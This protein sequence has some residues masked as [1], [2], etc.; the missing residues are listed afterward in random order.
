MPGPNYGHSLKEAMGEVQKCMCILKNET[1]PF[2]T[3]SLRLRP[4]LASYDPA[5]LHALS[6]LNAVLLIF[7]PTV[8][9]SHQSRTIHNDYCFI[10]ILSD[11]NI[12]FDSQRV[13][14]FT[15]CEPS[16]I[17]LRKQLACFDLYNIGKSSQNIR[18]NYRL[19][20]DR[21]MKILGIQ[22]I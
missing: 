13:N 9:P 5:L 15:F 12:F 3:G 2:S 18:T 19:S 17:V 4:N 20:Y 11:V 8:L 6:V 16:W 22:I 1:T 21:S 10:L 7:Y 14:L